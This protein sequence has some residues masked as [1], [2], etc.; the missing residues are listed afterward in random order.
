MALTIMEVKKLEEK[1]TEYYEV[2]TEI[3]GFT[4]Y[5]QTWYVKSDGT[6]SLVDFDNGLMILKNIVG[7]DCREMS[8]AKTLWC[9]EEY[10]ICAFESQYRGEKHE[11]QASKA[12]S[13]DSACQQW[14]SR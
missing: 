10:F 3:P 11:Q 8:C 9:R 2:H 6:D 4:R 13:T 5:R 1:M 7:T 12:S 14:Q